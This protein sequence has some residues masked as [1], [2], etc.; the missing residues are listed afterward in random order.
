MLYASV[1]FQSKCLSSILS[2]KRLWAETLCFSPDTQN[3]YIYDSLWPLICHNKEYNS[4]TFP[5]N[6]TFITFINSGLWTG[7][8]FAIVVVCCC[9]QD[10][11]QAVLVLNHSGGLTKTDDNQ[12]LVKKSINKFT[13][14]YSQMF[15]PFLMAYWVSCV[16]WLIERKTQW[17]RCLVTVNLHGKP[18]QLLNFTSCVKFDMLILAYLAPR[19]ACP[20][21]QSEIH[22]TKNLIQDCQ[23]V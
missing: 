20:L 17:S 2:W 4:L 10:F 19:H 16:S 18:F 8:H 15:E 11:D 6:A 9:M 12:I 1:V 7:L 22:H 13:T 5:S 23:N 3:R 14:F 21:W